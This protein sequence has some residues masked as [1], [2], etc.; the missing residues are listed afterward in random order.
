[1]E[2]SIENSE[3]WD[4]LHMALT[5][6]REQRLVYL[7][8]CGLRPREIVR[9]CPQ[10]RRDVQEI[11]RLRRTIIERLFRNADQLRWRFVQAELL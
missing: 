6:P 5:N 4:I 11:N 8:Y 10:E 1:M 3:I 2:D 9:F 7:I